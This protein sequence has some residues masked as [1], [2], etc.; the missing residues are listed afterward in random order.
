[1]DV[2]VQTMNRNHQPLHQVVKRLGLLILAFTVNLAL[3]GVMPFLLTRAPS[4]PSFESIEVPINV[5]RMK[6]K[7]SVERKEPEKPPEPPP[8]QTPKA[9]EPKP[10]IDKLT[11]P[12]ELNTRIPPMPTDL[13]L[14][15]VPANVPKNLDDIFNSGDLDAPLT[16]ILRIPPVYPLSAKSRGVQGWVKVHFIVDEAGHVSN[17]SVVASEPKHIFDNAVIRSVSG[18]RFKAGTVG[19]APVKTWAETVVRFHLD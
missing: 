9:M 11:L 16:V 18:W 10:V 19:G 5:I 1:M 12:F 7:E 8:P 17:V 2:T 4:K 3:F 14:S 15:V 13:A 6:L